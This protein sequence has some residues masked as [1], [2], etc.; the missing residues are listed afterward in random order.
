[1][2]DQNIKSTLE[3]FAAIFDEDT[4][5]EFKKLNL[6]PMKKLPEITSFDSKM[7]KIQD[8]LKEQLK[9][10]PEGK[11][12]CHKGLF[13]FTHI[14][15]IRN[16]FSEMIQTIEGTIC[17]TDKTHHILRKVASFFIEGKTIEFDLEN[18]KAYWVP[19]KIFRSHNEVINFFNALYRL[20]YGHPQEYLQEIKRIVELTSK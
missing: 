12:L 16:H 13:L 17:S 3:A 11:D 19:N 10:A 15:F 18:E 14:L 6:P 7:Y 2:Q 1:M 9:T 5:Q 20:Y 8:L 4:E